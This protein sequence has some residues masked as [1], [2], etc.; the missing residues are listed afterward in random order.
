MC[1]AVPGGCACARRI[2]LTIDYLLCIRVVHMSFLSHH[3]QASTPVGVLPTRVSGQ[4]QIL[5]EAADTG[6]LRYVV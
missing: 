3:V 2:I 1:V 6:C 5:P 4:R